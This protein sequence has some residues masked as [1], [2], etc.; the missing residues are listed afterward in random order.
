MEVKVIAMQERERERNDDQ[1]IV[2]NLLSSPYGTHDDF[3]SYTVILF[4]N[5][6]GNK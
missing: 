2:I 6:N 5:Q 4:E 3:I 1:R